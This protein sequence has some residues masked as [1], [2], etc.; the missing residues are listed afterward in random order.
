MRLSRPRAALF[1]WDNTLVDSFGVIHKAYN[2]TLAA[3]G[4]PTWTYEETC[5]RVARSMRESFPGLFGE[6]WREARERF[7]AAYAAHHL[8]FVRPLPGAADLLAALNGSGV[9]LGVVSNKNGSHLRREV[10]H[11]GWRDYFGRVVGAADAAEDKPSAAPVMLAL[12]GSGVAPGRDVWFVGDNA[13]DIACAEAAG[14]LP[15]IVGGAV[16]T[17]NAKALR[18]VA[19]RF[20]D[21][22]ELAAV[23]RRF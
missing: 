3:M 12:E 15:V 18:D 13:I 22:H 11:F 14:C 5:T 21:C 19:W 4:L 6:R 20:A 9:Y 17:G 8:D 2:E 7:Y 10:T 23:V 16:R 1:D